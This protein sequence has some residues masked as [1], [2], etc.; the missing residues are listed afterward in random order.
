MKRNIVNYTKEYLQAPFLQE[1]VEYRRRC[2]L[3]QLAKYPHSNILEIGCGMW[4]LFQYVEEYENYFICEPSA[5]FVANANQIAVNSGFHNVTVY[6]GCLEDIYQAWGGKKLDFIICSSLLH[7]VEDADRLLE[8]VYDIADQETVIHINVPNALSM[9]R[10][11]AKEMGLI[12]NVYEQSATQRK[13]Q[14]REIYDAVRFKDKLE[15]KN[16]QVLD[17]GSF[18]LKPFTHAQ[19][20]VLARLGILSAQML[21]GLDGL[22]K[23]FPEYG[24]EIYANV[25]KQSR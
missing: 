25:R 12:E 8:A 10:L 18:F 13:L 6:E 14:Q 4:P 17:E 1:N 23:Y 5:A 21:A 24:S 3:K 7:E 22:V 15:E 11:L 2:I 20:D 9:H 19:M 16:F